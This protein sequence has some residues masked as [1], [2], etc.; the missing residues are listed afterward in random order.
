MSHA[1][2]WV[3]GGGLAMTLVREI[4]D[5]V[6]LLADVVRNTR[7]IVDAVNDGR[8]YLA[9]KHPDARKA[10][11]ELLGQMQATVA[12][13]ADVTKVVSGYR[14]VTEGAAADFEPARFNSYVIDQRTQVA[15]LRGR[16]RELKA[17]CEAVRRIR[18][19]L[20]ARTRTRTW[21]SM[22][23]LIGVNGRKRATEMAHTLSDFYADD[24]RMIEVIQQ[25]LRLAQKAL[26][27]VDRALGPPG[28]AHPHN[29][30]SASAVLQTYAAVFEQPQREL[31]D[32]ADALSDAAN[33][34]TPA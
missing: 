13:L 30:A 2:R 10:F 5:A 28:A 3:L 8:Q 20:V 29:V 12:G 1:T 22:F 26:S 7:A 11:A 31:D 6:L 23:G 27:D 33:A 14:F 19:S 16:I 24:Q 21:T 32:L 25:M 9:S 34:L 17:D 4:A 18:D 15:E